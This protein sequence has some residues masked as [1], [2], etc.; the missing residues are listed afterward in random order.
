MAKP[1]KNLM[2]LLLGLVLFV[3]IVVGCLLYSNGKS[4]EAVKYKNAQEFKEKSTIPYYEMYDAYSYILH[5]KKELLSQIESLTFRH[6]K[7]DDNEY[8]IHMNFIQV[9]DYH[10]TYAKNGVSAPNENNLYLAFDNK[11]VSIEKDIN[12][13]GILINFSS[14]KVSYSIHIN[15]ENINDIDLKDYQQSIINY[16]NDV[17]SLNN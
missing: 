7:R 6:Y 12:F 14:D 13:P 5:D 15:I 11:E 1:L 4:F 8:W 16:I 9:C 17:T 2:I 10:I 3:C